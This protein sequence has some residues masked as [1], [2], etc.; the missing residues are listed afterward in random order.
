MAANKKKY[1]ILNAEDKLITIDTEAKASQAEKD[2][3]QM[4]INAGYTVRFK[5]QARAAA[6]RKRAKLTGFGKKKKVEA[7]EVTTEEK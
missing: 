7:A 2:V 3:V 5:S 1:F 4:Y 6:S